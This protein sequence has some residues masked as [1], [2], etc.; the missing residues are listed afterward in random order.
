MKPSTF[1]EALT[2][3][4]LLALFVLKLKID[5]S[6]LFAFVMGQAGKKKRLILSTS[7]T[8]STMTIFF[9]VLI[10]RATLESWWS[11]VEPE[12]LGSIPASS[13]IPSDENLPLE[14]VQLEKRE[15]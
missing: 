9:S 8:T 12:V 14:F 7:K 1:F 3:K 5:N 11:A 13:F 4:S 15:L 6:G 10:E 2:K